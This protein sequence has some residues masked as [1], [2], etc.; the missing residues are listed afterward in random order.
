MFEAFYEGWYKL[1]RQVIHSAL[2]GTQQVLE[3]LCPASRSDSGHSS[4]Q[5]PGPITLSARQQR[6]LEH[7]VRCPTT[8]QQIVK[9]S[10]IILALAAGQSPNRIARTLATTRTTVCKWWVRW[11]Q[12]SSAISLS[13]IHI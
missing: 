3:L 2:E 6:L 11:R 13:L 7:V 12:Q 5:P 10:R 9:R 4:A 8:P 1:G